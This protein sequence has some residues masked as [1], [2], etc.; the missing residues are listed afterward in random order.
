MG[1]FLEWY[2]PLHDSLGFI[3]PKERVFYGTFLGSTG[4]WMLLRIL[5]L[6]NQKLQHNNSLVASHLWLDTQRSVTYIISNSPPSNALQSDSFGIDL[7]SH[8]QYFSRKCR[9]HQ[10]VSVVSTVGSSCWGNSNSIRAFDHH[11]MLKCALQ[12]L[13]IYLFIY[14]FIL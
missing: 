1:S 5:F 13:S 14:L 4:I 12:V 6:K 8:T 11:V 7:N 2:E 10:K 9:K 3:K